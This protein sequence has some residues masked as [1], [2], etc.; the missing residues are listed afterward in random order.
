MGEVA[1]EK[2]EAVD[3]GGLES[4]RF[5]LWRCGGGVGGEGGLDGG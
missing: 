1:R 2:V 5:G 3:W 4:G